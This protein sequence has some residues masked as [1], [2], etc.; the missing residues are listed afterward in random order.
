MTIS[1]YQ[2]KPP[3]EIYLN[4]VEIADANGHLCTADGPAEAEAIL[5]AL[6]LAA[7]QGAAKDGEE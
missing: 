4:G 5:A 2:L 3:F 7:A 6:C 1:T